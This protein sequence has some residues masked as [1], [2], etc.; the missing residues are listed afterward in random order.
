MKVKKYL[1]TI[2]LI[3]ILCVG[4]LF[5]AC[6]LFGGKDDTTPS[7]D[8]SSNTHNENDDND[9]TL[10]P[11]IQS[12]DDSS[13][14]SPLDPDFVPDINKVYIINPILNNAYSGID[15]YIGDYEFGNAEFI[16]IPDDRQIKDIVGASNTYG[17][18]NFTSLPFLQEGA[19]MV[20]HD[21]GSSVFRFNLSPDYKN[22]Y[23]LNTNWADV[24]SMTALA[25]TSQY[26]AVLNNPDLKTFII[27]ATEFNRCTWE[28]VTTDN[29]DPNWFYYQYQNV[30]KEFYDLTKYL[31]QTYG[32]KDKTF[33]LSTYDGDNVFGKLYDQC[34]LGAN[35][36]ETQKLAL[37]ETYTRYLNARQDGI[38]KAVKE[39]SGKKAK[40]YGCIE[41]SHISNE[42]NGVVTRPRLVDCVVPNT[43]ADLYSFADGYTTLGE[44]DLLTELNYLASKAPNPNADFAGKRNI[45]LGK[46]GYPSNIAGDDQQQYIV[47][48]NAIKDAVEYGVQYVVYDSY[49]CNERTDTS[50]ED[51]P[52]NG[53]MAGYWLIKP[54]GSYS[55]IFW[56]LK[57]LND[58]LNYLTKTPQLRLEV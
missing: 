11:P 38:N 33:I 5:S 43:Y 15:L 10:N 52:T 36:G 42:I 58:N 39:L 57:G 13:D 55:T 14:F 44:K 34:T 4:M 37:I 29:R 32:N 28:D 41:V 26:K 47:C 17:K 46:I 16:N 23:A 49:C 54:D 30:T 1:I 21:L 6:E 3:C 18:Y 50:L 7:G 51:R 9:E 12:G 2:I 45:I 25:S 8:N 35:N 27:D 48:R 22:I 40:V 53:N 56:Y 20:A 24:D 31:L 19:E